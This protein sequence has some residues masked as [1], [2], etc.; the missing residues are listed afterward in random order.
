LIISQL[1]SLP[2]QKRNYRWGGDAFGKES[3]YRISEV[4]W[5]PSED[6]Y[7]WIL[8]I[9][10][11]NC[12]VNPN[13]EMWNYELWGYNDDIQYTNYYDNGGHY[14]WHALDLRSIY[15]RME[16]FL[17][18]YRLTDPDELEG[19]D[20]IKQWLLGSLHLLK[21]RGQAL[22]IFSSFVLHRVTPLT[23]KVIERH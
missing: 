17:V 23:Q 8:R 4:S 14:D 9:E 21:G 22:T 13:K 20:Q 10:F 5:V 3:E 15:V 1:E 11:H 18:F 2:K 19:G 7:I 6:K 16:K 12:A